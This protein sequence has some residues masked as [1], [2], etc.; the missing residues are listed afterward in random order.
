MTSVNA[1]CYHVS[2]DANVVMVN[3]SLS[4][5]FWFTLL[6]GCSL[7]NER[8]SSEMWLFLV[9]EWETWVVRFIRHAI[10]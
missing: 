7:L 9:P 3:M 8:L 5:F 4:S 6:M 10:F 1:I 2:C